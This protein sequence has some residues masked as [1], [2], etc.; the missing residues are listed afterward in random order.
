MA[1]ILLGDMK[2]LLREIKMA[3]NIQTRL[4]TSINPTIFN[5]EITGISLPARMISGDYYDFYPMADNK[6]RFIIADVMGKG[7]PAAM[8]MILTRGAF[9]SACTTT[10]DP[11]QTLMTMNDALY[12]DLRTL[13]CFVTA[14]CAEWDPVSKTL[15]YATAGHS[16]PLCIRSGKP[17]FTDLSIKS[18]VFLGGLP[19]QKYSNL[20]IE[21]E[22]GD[23]VLFYTDGIIEA[24]NKQGELYKLERLINVAVNQTGK[25]VNEIESTITNSLYDFTSGLPQKDDIT[26]IILKINNEW[27][28]NDV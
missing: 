4:L 16:S 12:S 1:E 11:A 21:L 9:R 6:I 27:D 7:I 13:G 5:G 23:Y 24:Q 14:C 19:N 17:L 2:A 10:T 25:S 18:G 26:M 15:S 3:R 28:D 22:L 20:S 8:L